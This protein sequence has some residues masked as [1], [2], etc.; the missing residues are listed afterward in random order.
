M[1][2]GEHFNLCCILTGS[3]NCDKGRS[4]PIQ[5]VCY[6]ALPYGYSAISCAYATGDN[7]QLPIAKTFS[8]GLVLSG[9]RVRG[10]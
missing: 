8:S 5:A 2:L 10:R 1:I 7:V 9:E 4:M 3:C 6:Q